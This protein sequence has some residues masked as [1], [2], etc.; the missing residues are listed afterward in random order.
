MDDARVV[1]DFGVPSAGFGVLAER[2]DVGELGLQGGGE[3]DAGREVVALFAD[4]GVGAGLGG[5]VAGAVA[6]CNTSFE[7][8]GAEQLDPVGDHCLPEWGDGQSE[9]AVGLAHGLV[10]GGPDSG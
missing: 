6:V 5:E 3:F 7:H 8:L 2:G 10:V 9:S 1:S 4:V